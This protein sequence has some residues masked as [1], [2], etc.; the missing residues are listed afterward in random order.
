MLE[1]HAQRARDRTQIIAPTLYYLQA[2]E[3]T[4]NNGN[5]SILV[6]NTTAARILI[7]I[8]SINHQ[9]LG[10]IDLV[11]RRIYYIN[12]RGESYKFEILRYLLQVNSINPNKFKN[13]EI[14]FKQQLNN[15]DYSFQVITNARSLTINSRLA[16]VIDIKELKL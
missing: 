6:I 14:D 11:Y 7:P 4:D 8:N 13:G 16:L 1:F 15:F 10:V 2:Y 9:T 3:V 12:S 5:L